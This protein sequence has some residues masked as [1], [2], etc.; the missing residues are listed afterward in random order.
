[1][2]KLRD[3]F[4]IEAI[5]SQKA[6]FWRQGCMSNALASSPLTPIFLA[7]IAFILI[8]WNL[9]EFSFSHQGNKLH[10]DATS[11]V[12][13][14]EDGAI[15][16][17]DLALNFKSHESIV[18][19]FADTFAYRNELKRALENNILQLQG[20]DYVSAIQVQ[21]KRV[22]INGTEIQNLQ[23]GEDL[24]PESEY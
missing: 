24:V 2:Q 6:F 21:G 14:K 10:L 20:S 12:G 15:S 17:L 1:M 19:D 22:I 5:F 4:R 9:N 3:V 11:E 8:I 7:K 18:K 13:F 16:S 23:E